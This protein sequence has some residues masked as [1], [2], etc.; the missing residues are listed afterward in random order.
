MAVEIGGNEKKKREGGREREELLSDRRRKKEGECR[1]L[2]I[3]T[4]GRVGEERERKRKM[5]FVASLGKR[6]KQTEK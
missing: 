4:V 1:W 3:S 6:S 2:K 5:Y